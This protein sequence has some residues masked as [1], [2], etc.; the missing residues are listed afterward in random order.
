MPICKLWNW[1]SNKG[2]LGYAALTS[3]GVSPR[4]TI[5]M[6][7]FIPFLLGMSYALLP[8]VDNV[9]SRPLIND[10]SSEKGF[11]NAT[12]SP[13]Y[14]SA[15]GTKARVFHLI[16]DLGQKLKQIPPLFTYM[17]PLFLVYFAEYL[18]NQGLFELLY[19][20]NAVIK[21]HT[22]QYRFVKLFLATHPLYFT[23]LFLTG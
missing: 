21:E 20:K 4:H 7:C 11:A 2:S 13:T 10:D 12:T 22:L 17:I 23:T 8:P 6:M 14:A 19:F 5:L 15:N 1:H 9:E 18:I 16:N 3:T